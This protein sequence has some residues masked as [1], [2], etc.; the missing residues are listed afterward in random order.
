MVGLPGSLSGVGSSS[1]GHS[2]ESVLPGCLEEDD[3]R[4]FSYVFLIAHYVFNYPRV[5]NGM[6]L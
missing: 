1:R 4:F 3:F 6:M 5:L 2:A